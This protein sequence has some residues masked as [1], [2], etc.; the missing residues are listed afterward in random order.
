MLDSIK[1][2]LPS[3]QKRKKLLHVLLQWKEKCEQV[4][5]Y[6]S[7]NITYAVIYAI[8]CYITLPFNQEGDLQAIPIPPALPTTTAN[9]QQHGN[10]QVRN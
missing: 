8:L 5:Y 10:D 1:H 2:R 4:S 3:P 9:Q 6:E 7:I